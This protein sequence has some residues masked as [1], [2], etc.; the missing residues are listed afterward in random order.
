MAWI[1]L[2][3]SCNILLVDKKNDSIVVYWAPAYEKYQETQDW[4]LLYKNPDK[5]IDSLKQK[6]NKEAKDISFLYCPAFTN[7]HKN[8]FVFYNSITSKFEVSSVSSNSYS[9]KPKNDNFIIASIK[10]PPT[11]DSLPILSYNLKW[12]FFCEEDLNLEVTPPYF[13]QHTYSHEAA[14]VPGSFNISSWFRP[15]NA[16]FHLWKENT[17]I[18]IN[19]EDPLF[20][21]RFCTDKKVIL[22]RFN[23]NEDLTKIYTSCSNYPD[24]FGRFESLTTMYET[25]KKTSTNKLVAKI[26]KE[27]LIDE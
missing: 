11:L 26:I 8:T 12:L 25:F 7:M 1:F 21:A 17:E 18:S 10:R 13:S 27:N 4:N 2:Y 19:K 16:D 24:M 20:Y 5:L 3:F 15:I 22:K 9:V 14:F 23:I 6:R